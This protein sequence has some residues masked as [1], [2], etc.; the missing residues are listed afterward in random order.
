MFSRQPV[1][2]FNLDSLEHRMMLHGGFHGLRVR[3]P[4]PPS[5]VIQ[6]DLDAIKADK[7]QLAADQKAL[8]ATLRADSR[9]IKA[10]VRALEPTLTPLY[11]TLKT[12]SIAAGIC[13]WRISPVARPVIFRRTMT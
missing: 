10:A 3:I 6:A 2:K 7:A 13:S 8:S 5:A 11:D 1:A 4:D 12:D 9:A